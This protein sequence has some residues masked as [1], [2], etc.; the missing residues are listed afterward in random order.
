MR[1]TLVAEA[2]Q[3]T[4]QHPVKSFEVSCSVLRLKAAL[5]VSIFLRYFGQ[6]RSDPDDHCM[7]RNI[8]SNG[9]YFD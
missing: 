8:T 6:L 2:K 3:K 1:I 9:E 4:R 5:H 7:K